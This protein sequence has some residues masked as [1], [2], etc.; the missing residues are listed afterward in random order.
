MKR[1][2]GASPEAGIRSYIRAVGT[3]V[4]PADRAY[5]QNKLDRRLG[6]FGSAVLRASVRLEDVNGPRGGLDKRCR[7]KV[8]LRGLAA[9]VV[10]S[11]SHSMQAAMDRTLVKMQSAVTQTL[12]R[13][14]ALPI[15]ARHGA[16]H[17]PIADDQ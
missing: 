11:H 17:V 7:I 13:R 16:P 3:P 6:K 12:G 1:T 10:Q 14:R 9:V 4:S 15:K 2:G 8:S 5:L